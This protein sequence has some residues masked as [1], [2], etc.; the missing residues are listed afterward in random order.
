MIA[1]HLSRAGGGGRAYRYGGEEFA[2]V[3][4]G[5][6]V[7]E[8]VPHLEALRTAVEDY[9]MQLRGEDRPGESDEGRVRRGHGSRS[10]IL[11]VTI[12]IGVAER[13]TRH[14][15]PDQV[16]R[17]ADQALYRAKNRGRNRLSR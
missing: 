10:N 6:T 17:L 2:V 13:D 9:R 14:Q 5:K 15:D 4:P 7:R 11:K 8:S 16:L 12:S 3:F 1:A